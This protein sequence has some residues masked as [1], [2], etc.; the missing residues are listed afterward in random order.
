MDGN[1]C[2]YLPVRR[3]AETYSQSKSTV[4]R[5][6]EE[7]KATGRYSSYRVTIND[8]GDKLVNVLVYED[9]LYYRTQLKNRNLAKNLPPF[10]PVEV[11]KNWG[12]A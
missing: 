12:I 10:D 6:L 8:D 3:V 11:R 2:V 7:L 4:N 1:V 5:I 9:Y